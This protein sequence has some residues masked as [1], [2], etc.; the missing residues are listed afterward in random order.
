[1][2][3]PET[4]RERIVEYQGLTFDDAGIFICVRDHA[5]RPFDYKKYRE[6][7]EKHPDSSRTG[8]HLVDRLMDGWAVN[9]KP[10]KFTEVS[11]YKNRTSSKER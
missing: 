5:G 4:M 1:M 9:T 6:F 3:E 8:L 2:E 10:G 11:F 7:D